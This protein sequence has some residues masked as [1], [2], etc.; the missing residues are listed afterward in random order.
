M[1]FWTAAPLAPIPRWP[2]PLRAILR[3]YFYRVPDSVWRGLMIDGE[4]ERLGA[5]APASGDIGH[6]TARRDQTIFGQQRSPVIVACEFIAM[7]DE[8]P[9]VLPVTRPTVLDSHEHPAAVQAF[10]LDYKLQ[11]AFFKRGRGIAFFQ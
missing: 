8:Q 11:L 3:D 6:R 2:R 5:A 9:V 1:P 4:N 10:A 7:L